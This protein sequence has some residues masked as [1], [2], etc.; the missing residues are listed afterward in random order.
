[1]SII[2]IDPECGSPSES[3][4]ELQYVENSTYNPVNDYAFTS[5]AE[6][7]V[8][9]N[10]PKASSVF[11]FFQMPTPGSVWRT[12]MV[13]VYLNLATSDTFTAGFSNTTPANGNSMTR[14]IR[15]K[16]N[17]CFAYCSGSDSAFSKILSDSFTAGFHRVFIFTCMS[18][19]N[20]P[21]N[22][23]LVYNF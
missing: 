21:D 7:T 19:A 13:D 12:F 1:M 23:Q 3:D 9:F 5:T 4:K 11:T 16:Q 17:E 8:T 20:S 14:Y 6:G 10:L 22:S 15:F 18:P 2:F